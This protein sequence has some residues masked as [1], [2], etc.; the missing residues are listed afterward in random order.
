MMCEAWIELEQVCPQVLSVWGLKPMDDLRH[1]YNW[2]AAFA[3]CLVFL[4]LVAHA[5]FHNTSFVI[6]YNESNALSHSRHGYQL[7]N[8]IPSPF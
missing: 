4:F 5:L 3:H 2:P 1:S 6:V 8:T 7:S